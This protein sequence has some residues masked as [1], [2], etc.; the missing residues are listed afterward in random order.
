MIKALFLILK[1][2]REVE[3]NMDINIK[4]PSTLPVSKRTD[5]IICI[6]KNYDKICRL[7]NSLGNVCMY[8]QF[9]QLYKSLNPAISDSYLDKKVIQVTN[10]MKK[11]KLIEIDYINKYKYIYLKK[12]AF[13][14]VTGDYTKYKKNNMSII[15]KEKNFK[16]SIMKVEYYLRY[17]QLIKLSNMDEQLLYITQ[18]LFNAKRKDN[19]LPYNLNI[20][21]KI[22]KDKGIHN[23]YEEVYNLSQTDLVRILWIDLNNIYSSLRKQNQTISEIPIYLKLFKHESSLTL[24]YAPTIIIF[25]VF[26]KN[27][28]AKKI[29]DLFSKYF[30]IL[31]NYTRDMRSSYVKNGNLGWEGYNHFGYSIK[32][33]GYNKLELEEKKKFIDKYVND[34]PNGIMLDSSE[35]EYIDISKYFLHSSQKNDVFDKIDDTFDKLLLEKTKNLII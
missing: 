33:I 23:C 20:L 13:I 17:N 21:T 34:N 10:E 12:F 6:E 1:T 16:I 26:N 29:N 27:Y 7:L 2:F 30:N 28:Y 24:H 3:N 32:L 15:L 25:D 14:F 8:S 22:L 9:K 19:S 11:L 5:Y 18:L 4:V 35:I 31:S